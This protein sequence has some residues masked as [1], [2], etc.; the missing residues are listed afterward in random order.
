MELTFNQ[1]GKKFVAEFTASADFNLHIEKHWGGEVSIL[2]S[3]VDEEGATYVQELK[4]GEYQSVLD[5]DFSEKVYPKHYRIV[6][7]TQ[8][9]RAFV[10]SEGEISAGSGNYVYYSGGMY[11]FAEAFALVSILK[12]KGD[13]TKAF[14]TMGMAQ[15][16]TSFNPENIIGVGFDLS[17]KINDGLVT[18]GDLIANASKNWTQIT[19]EEFYRDPNA[20]EDGRFRVLSDYE[21][22][23]VILQYDEGMTWRDWV[24]SSYNLNPTT[25]KP[26]LKIDGEDIYWKYSDGMSGS[27]QKEQDGYSGIGIDDLIINKTYYAVIIA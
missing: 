5:K 26:Y 16:G 19:E 6:S 2:K 25:N 15:F 17:M 18:V 8:Y 9:L 11:D 23:D 20:L 13:S 1:E 7:S 12:V 24:N 4:M 21:N 3:T 22:T 14:L 27:I 10:T